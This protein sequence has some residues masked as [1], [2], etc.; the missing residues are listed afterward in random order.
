MEIE[1][2]LERAA[3][4]PRI[5]ASDKRQAFAVIGEIAGR[6]YALKPSTVVSG[7]MRREL[8][9]STG[10]GHGVAT[11]H[12]RMRGLDRMRGIF[13]RLEAPLEFGALDGQPVDLLFALLAPVD[14]SSAHLQALAKVSRLLRSAELRSQLRAASGIDA[15]HAL[16]VR[17]IRSDAA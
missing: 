1:H 12:A 2:L 3:I 15:I 7:L 9:G 16:L 14:S 8:Q 4:A 13:V 10:V 6:N 5:A 17:D 11:P